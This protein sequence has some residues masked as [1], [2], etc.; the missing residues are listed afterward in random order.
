MSGE[1]SGWSAIVILT[2]KLNIILQLIVESYIALYP[3][4]KLTQCP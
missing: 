3:D 4:L 1:I 2:K